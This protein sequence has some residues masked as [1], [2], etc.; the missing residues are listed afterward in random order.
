MRQEGQKNA[1]A[2]TH[3]VVHAPPAAV[4]GHLHS[5]PRFTVELAAPAS[6]EVSDLMAGEAGEAGV[7]LAAP[8]SP[9]EASDTQ[10]RET[11]SGA[12][13]GEVRVARAAEA[14]C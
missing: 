3:K 12:S 1:L 8:A 10:S 13:A 5:G 11:A 7:E 6:P 14:P 2:I 4:H 9:N